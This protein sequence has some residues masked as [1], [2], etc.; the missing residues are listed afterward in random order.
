MEKSA[1]LNKPPDETTIRKR[2]FRKEYPRVSICVLSYNH[3]PFLTQTLNGLLNQIT[4]FG[5]EILIH[6]DA[7]KDQSQ[8]I[9]KSYQK[10]YPHI[11]KPIYQ[12]LNQWSQGVNPSVAYNYP[13]ANADYVAWCE[14]DDAWID[15]Y[16]LAKQVALLDKTPDVNLSFHPGYF[17]N[18]SKIDATITCLGNYS[19]PKHSTLT[20]IRSFSEVVHRPHGFI[21]TAA[22]VARQAVKA[23][24]QAFMGPRPYMRSGDVF[25]QLFGALPNG[26]VYLPEAM[27]LY[28]FRTEHSLTRGMHLDAV[29]W[30]E[31]NLAVAKAYTE[32]N[33][34]TKG[35]IESHLKALVAQRLR[36]AFGRAPFAKNALETPFHLEAQKQ[37]RSFSNL[38]RNKC[39]VLNSGRQ[40]IIIYG[41]GSGCYEL[42]KHISPKKIAFIVDRDGMKAGATIGG[43][44]VKVFEDIEEGC[45]LKIVVSILQ[46]DRKAIEA[47]ARAKAI[48]LDRIYYFYDQLIERMDMAKLLNPSSLHEENESVARVDEGRLL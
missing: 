11:I 34:E 16:K 1:H 28:R 18:H 38:E 4:R 48:P 37:Y 5:F 40:D 6:D 36:W 39:R 41:C 42:M 7:S 31:H 13:R 45:P 3:G 29:K 24:L 27:S 30:V 25:M 9:I 22:C 32:L 43:R 44:P 23:K 26:A 46:P 12:D 14:G 17:V 19:N 35:A 8:S 33:Y 21:P 47:K 20:Q 15:S 10:R 2:W